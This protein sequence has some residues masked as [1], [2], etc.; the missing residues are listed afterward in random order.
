VGALHF[1]LAFLRALCA[2][3]RSLRPSIASVYTVPT[4]LLT[5]ILALLLATQIQTTLQTSLQKT[6][7][8]AII[9]DAQTGT[10]LAAVKP[11]E[12]AQLQSLPGS[13]LKPIFL[14]EALRQNA[15]QPTTKVFC[16]RN[17]HINGRDLQCTHPQNN[18]A[19][20]A[21]EALAYSCNTYFADLAKRMT[22]QTLQDTAVHYGLSRTPHLFP[23]ETEGTLTTPHTTEEKQLFVL[24]L[25][26]ITASPAQIAIAYSKLW[27]ELT[28][29]QLQP[30][31]Q[32]LRDSVRFGMAH[33]AA[34]QGIDII[35]KTGTAADPNNPRSHGWFAGIATLH[36][37]PIVIVIYLPNANGADAATLARHFL[38]AYQNNPQ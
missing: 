32:G 17:L 18:I 25:A 12:A 10:I 20:D 30:V 23:K 6:P 5:P 26:G 24:G 2:P 13:I 21:I 3:P 1:A 9:L 8:T 36:A 22:P 29:P 11:A 38:Q 15:I 37:R 16:R 35:G 31:A 28:N 27:R 34:Q 14:A 33:N 19:F 7:A 4:L